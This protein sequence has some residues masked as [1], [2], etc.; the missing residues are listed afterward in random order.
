[1]NPFHRKD[2]LVINRD[3]SKILYNRFSWEKIAALKWV[4]S[5]TSIISIV[6][7]ELHHINSA[8]RLPVFS[9]WYGYVLKHIH[10]KDRIVMEFIR[11]IA[12]VLF[13]AIVID[14][15]GIQPDFFAGLVE[16]MGNYIYPVA[17][18]LIAWL[19]MPMVVWMFE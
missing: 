5:H 18:L 8:K 19:L 17:G 12:A 3:I 9:A 7:S 13:A 4:L 16:M 10:R 11:I 15:N 14:Y 1:M 6:K 2:F